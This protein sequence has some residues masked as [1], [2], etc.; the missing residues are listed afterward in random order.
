MQSDGRNVSKASIGYDDD[1]DGNL[2]LSNSVNE[3]LMPDRLRLC[4][5]GHEN[6]TEHL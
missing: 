5:D 3:F 2:F 4:S 6:A 1:D